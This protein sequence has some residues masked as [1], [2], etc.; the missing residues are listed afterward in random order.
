[1]TQFPE[2]FLNAEFAATLHSHHPTQTL[3]AYLLDLGHGSASRGKVEGAVEMNRRKASGFTLVELLVVIGI[4]AL[5]MSILLPVLAKARE[6]A[7]TIKCASNLRSVGQ[8]ILMYAVQFKDTF[9]PAYFYEGMTIDTVAKTETPDSATAGYVHWSSFIYGGVS[10]RPDYKNLDGWDAFRCPT[11]N[12]GGLSPTNTFDANR[13]PGQSNDDGSVI[14]QQAP[15]L[16]YTANQAI[17]PRNKFVIGFQGD[18][19][20]VDKFV[21]VGSVRN[22]SNTILATEWNQNWQIVADSGHGSGGAN[23]CKSHRPVHGF[24]IIGG[25]LNVETVGADPFGG[26]PTLARCHLSDLAGDPQ[27][28]VTSNT[29]LDWV[30]RNHGYP[31]KKLDGSGF[32]LRTTNFLYCDGHVETKSIRDTFAPFQWGDAFYSVDGGDAVVP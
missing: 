6:S 16:A 32:D 5:L 23:V 10:G 30:G 28:G 19:A 20:R 13:D 17:C 9:P 15:R 4:I 14:D 21:K 31:S 11:I 2:T 22:S 7:N 25:E 3:Q 1:M 12:Q 29:R 18:T 8:G 27:P 24:K 26:R